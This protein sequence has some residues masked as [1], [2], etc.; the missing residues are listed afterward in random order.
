MMSQAHRLSTGNAFE[1]E[2]KS[3]SGEALVVLLSCSLLFFNL[4]QILA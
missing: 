1:F 4:L 2:V 3:A